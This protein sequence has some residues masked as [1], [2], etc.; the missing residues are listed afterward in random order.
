MVGWPAV[1]RFPLE[2]AH[3]R[4][5]VADLAIGAAIVNFVLNLGLGWLVVRDRAGIAFDADFGEPS[6]IGELL[7][8]CLLLPFFTGIIVTPLVRKMVAAG[9]L[10]AL[11]W[12][13]ADHPWLR[14]LPGR[15]WLRA[16]AV[17]AVCV[18]A[19]AVP[20]AAALSAAGVSGLDSGDYLI[21]KAVGSGLLAAPVT[22]LFGLAALAE[23]EAE[24]GR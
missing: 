22:P 18:V 24:V 13:R 21:A 1:A 6:L 16:L 9:R 11:S 19:V 8:T 14:R 7:G 2:P 15:T 12:R 23:A 5:L 20:I 4:Y 3:E 17:G 10:P